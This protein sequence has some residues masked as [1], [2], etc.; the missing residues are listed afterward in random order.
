MHCCGIVSGVLQQNSL[1]EFLRDF[2]CNTPE[3]IPQCIAF[4]EKSKTLI[5]SIRNKLKRK[6]SLNMAQIFSSYLFFFC[7][8]VFFVFCFCFYLFCFLFL[9]SFTKHSLRRGVFKYDK[10]NQPGSSPANRSRPRSVFVIVD[11]QYMVMK[12]IQDKFSEVAFELF[13]ISSSETRGI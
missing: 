2:Y 11:F 5:R 8:F 6:E 4:S 9:N 10:K 7:F 12:K 1:E 13:Q 3:T